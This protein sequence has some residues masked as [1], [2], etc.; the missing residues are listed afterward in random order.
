MRKNTLPRHVDGPGYARPWLTEARDGDSDQHRNQQHLQQIA[1]R[2]G[3]DEGAGDDRHKMGDE[4]VP[5]RLPHI[6][7]NHVGSIVAGSILKPA[8]GRIALATIRP[9]TSAIVETTSK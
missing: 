3:V 9:I 4:A 1:L 5:F 8:P 7:C 2:E 6:A